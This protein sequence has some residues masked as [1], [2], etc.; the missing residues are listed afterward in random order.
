M[1]QIQNN[2]GTNVVNRDNGRNG[3]K[4][5]AREKQE[6]NEIWSSGRE[7]RERIDT[8]LTLSLA[9][10]CN[11]IIAIQHDTCCWTMSTRQS[12]SI[13]LGPLA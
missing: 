5:R 8:I 2:R 9:D 3:E 1:W 7:Q 6:T 10:L 11:Q 4:N 12:T 13:A